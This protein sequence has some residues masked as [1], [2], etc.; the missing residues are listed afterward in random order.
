VKGKHNI[1]D[2]Y[3]CKNCGKR[4][5]HN[6]SHQEMVALYEIQTGKEYVERDTIYVCEKCHKYLSEC[7]DA[8]P[9]EVYDREGE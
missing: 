3:V 7:K 6:K 8:S 2:E 4:D 5:V 1:G 9:H